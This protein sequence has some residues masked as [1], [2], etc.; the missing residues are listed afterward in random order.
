MSQTSYS[1]RL[2]RATGLAFVAAPVCGVAAAVVWRSVR[3]GEHFWLVFAGLV[4]IC[5][6]AIWA[7]VP[8]WN[9]LDDMQ[10]QYHTVSW[11]W[12]GV[13]GGIVA[14]MALIAASGAQSQASLGGLSV[15]LGQT[16]AFLVFW[17]VWAWRSRSPA[18]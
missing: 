16:V 5:A 7:C 3:P 2:R 11:Y 12:G 15:L 18:S 10:K 13:G 17:T 9:R 6:L 4:L 1:A 14:L 8:W